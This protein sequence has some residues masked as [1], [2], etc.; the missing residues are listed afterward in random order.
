[1]MARRRTNLRGAPR[2]RREGEIRIAYG[3]VPNSFTYKGGFL[4]VHWVNGKMYGDTRSP[5]GLDRDAAC[6]IAERRARA[7]AAQFRGDWDVRITKGCARG[8]KERSRR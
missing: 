1:M 5:R 8:R 2:V 6:A 4:P 7:E 3:A